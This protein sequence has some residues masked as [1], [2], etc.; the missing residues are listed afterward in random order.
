MDRF[1]VSRLAVAL[2]RERDAFRPHQVDFGGPVFIEKTDVFLVLGGI[3]SS[4]KMTRK[5]W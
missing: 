4:A 1:Q 5:E 2:R 3:E